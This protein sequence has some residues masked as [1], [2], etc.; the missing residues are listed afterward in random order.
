ME[1][2]LALELIFVLPDL[3]MFYDTCIMQRVWQ[4]IKAKP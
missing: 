1:Q 3:S 4:T 2:I